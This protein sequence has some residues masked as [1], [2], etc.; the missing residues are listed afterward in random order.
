MG[1]APLRTLGVIG[2]ARIHFIAFL[3]HIIT[4]T[5][6]W[7]LKVS[8]GRLGNSF[9]GV[10]VL[11]LHTVGSRTGKKRVTPLFNLQHEEKIIL[12]ASNGGNAKNPGWL[13]NLKANP[14]AMVNLKG[15]EMKMHAH[16]ADAEEFELYW[17]MVIEMFSVWG[18]I[19]D[20]SI[21]KFPLA[22]LEPR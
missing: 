9:L 18:G 22:V 16:V 19:Q 15:K 4:P 11:L 14:E 12:V 2:R 17:P 3:K 5:N 13:H 6:M 10:S 20:K 1:E 21:R 8:K 7:L